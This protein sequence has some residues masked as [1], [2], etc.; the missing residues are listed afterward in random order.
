MVIDRVP[1]AKKV[2]DGGL[3]NPI[4]EDLPPSE[5]RELSEVSQTSSPVSLEKKVTWPT[6]GSP[7]SKAAILEPDVLGKADLS[8]Y[9][10]LDLKDQQEAWSILREYVDV[11]TKDNLNLGW[12]SFV[13]HKI[14]LEEGAGP[15]KEHYRRV[16]HRLYDKVQITFK[17]WPMSEL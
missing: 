5:Q 6:P 14:T 2:P 16:P 15:V 13:K 9:A 8:G 7:Q 11:F 12:T 17:K 4:G 1:T 10:E 3:L